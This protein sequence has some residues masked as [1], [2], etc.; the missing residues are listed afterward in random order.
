M[1]WFNSPAGGAHHVLTNRHPLT[2][3][4]LKGLD[5]FVYEVITP[6]PDSNYLAGQAEQYPTVM[7]DLD[8]NERASIGLRNNTFNVVQILLDELIQKKVP[9]AIRNAA[10]SALFSTLDKVRA[11]WRQD[12]DD[13]SDG[14]HRARCAHRSAAEEGRRTAQEEKEMDPGTD[15]PS[16]WTKTPAAKSFV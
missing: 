5:P 16:A 1:D 13:L 3:F 8:G 7:L 12:L 9:G 10:L 15:Q 14:A 4:K 11:E 2:E 6:S